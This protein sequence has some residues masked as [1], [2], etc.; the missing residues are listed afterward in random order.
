MKT[1]AIILNTEDDEIEQLK[2]LLVAP[3]LEQIKGVLYEM[4]ELP[5]GPLLTI[6]KLERKVI[7][8]F[9]PIGNFTKKSQVLV[10]WD[11]DIWDIRGDYLQV[12]KNQDVWIDKVI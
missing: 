11:L 1:V 9:G 3:N 2:K 4:G 12:V 5:V 7:L 6:K 8:Y 10:T